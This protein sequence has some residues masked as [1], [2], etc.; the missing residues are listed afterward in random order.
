MFTSYY[1]NK[2]VD[3]LQRGQSFSLPTTQYFGLLTSTKGP[4]QDSFAYS[5]SDTISLTANDGKTHLYSCTTG[6][7]TASSQSTL[8]PGVEDEVIT[9]GTAVF[10]EQATALRAGTVVEASYTGYSRTGVVCS[11]ADWAGT[12]GAGTTAVSSGTGIAATSN[13]VTITVGASNT[14]AVAYVWG[15]ARWDAS[16]SGNM[17]TFAGLNT[18]KTINPGDPAPFFSPA[19]LTFTLD[20]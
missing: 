11:L 19:S 17:L 12:Q 1:S 3:L 13:N 2:L 7:T 18:V 16:T 20:Q 8:Y 15:E 5:S 4:R 6:G 9:D 14:G 10:T